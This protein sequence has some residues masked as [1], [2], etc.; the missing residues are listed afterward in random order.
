MV[1]G[2]RNS[3]G[4]AAESAAAVYL[5]RRG[6]RIVYRRWRCREGELDV[7]AYDPAEQQV[8][9]VEVKARRT[10]TYGTAAESIGPHKQRTLEAAVERYLAATGC[11]SRYRVDLV[12]VDGRTLRVAEHLRN[13]RFG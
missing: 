5:Q 9:F 1:Q 12:T 4:V 3:L 11:R 2:N 10:T 6:Y 8:V 7:V 13:V